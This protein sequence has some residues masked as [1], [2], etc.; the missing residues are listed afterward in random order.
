MYIT[1][2]TPPRDLLS[3]LGPLA[4]N[5]HLTIVDCFTWGK[6]KGADELLA[7]YYEDRLRFPGRII[8]VDEPLRAG[9]VSETLWGAYASLEGE[10]RLIFESLTGMQELWGDEDA[11]VRFYAETCPRLF[12]LETLSYWIVKKDR[13]SMQAR[14]RMNQIAQKV[15]DLGLRR[16]KTYL[17]PVKGQEQSEPKSRRWHKYRIEGRSRVSFEE[18][19]QSPG[20]IEVSRRLKEVRMMRGLRQSELAK[21]VGVTASTI[22]QIESNMIMPSLST[23]FKIAERLSVEPGYFLE[24][25][26]QST[27]PLVFSPIAGT[28]TALPLVPGGSAT[29]KSVLPLMPDCHAEVYFIE[30]TPHSS[31]SCHFLIH[32]GE[33]IGCLLS[34]RLR[35]TVNRKVHTVNA[36]ELVY[37]SSHVPDDWENPEKTPAELLWIV[38]K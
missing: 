13:P 31:L 25:K 15:I 21:S 30:I 24:S 19:S 32:K 27:E 3:Q 17:T 29:V 2:D 38:I 23:L 14:S 37:L 28:E 12:E 11:A 16:G 26:A 36:G 5:P 7:F 33:E 1:F 9:L 34:G 18:H 35:F 22:S 8:R 20:E 6:G 4:D 10:V